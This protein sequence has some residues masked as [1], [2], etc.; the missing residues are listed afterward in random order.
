[1][2][3]RVPLRD[4]AGNILKWYG[5]LTDIEDRKRAEALL[6]GEKRVLELVAKGNPLAEIL[7]SLCTLVEEQASDALASILLV[8]GDRLKHGG[9]PSLP[10]A[11]TDAID[12]VL[13]GPSVGSCGTAAY[14]GQQVVVEDIATDSLWTNFR[15]AA[16]PHGLHACWSTPVFSSHGQ[17]IATFAMYYREPR[18]PTQ[19][20]QEII[21]Q[22]THLAGVAIE[23]KVTYD[24]LQRSEAYLAEAQRL[25]H[26]GSWAIEPINREF[27]YWSDEMFRILDFDPQHGKAS[28]QQMWQLIHPQD[29]DRVKELSDRTV[30]E[31]KDYDYE[32]RVVLPSG[33]VKHLLT[34]GH[35]DLN[36]QG[37][38]IEVVG[39]TIDVT[40][41]K[42]YLSDLQAAE[43]KFRG[44]LESAP[45]AVAVVNRVGTIVLVN[46]QLEKLFGYQRTE[47]LGNK[48]E[49][50]LP[51]RFRSKHPELRTAF[52]AD[53]HTRPM[54]S[55]LELYGLHK[56][57]R[58]FPVEV[59][60]S[61]LETEEGVLISGA[62]RD[63]TDRKQAE[64]KIRHSEAELRQLWM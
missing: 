43:Q 14:R 25:T 7:D 36:S 46:A 26:T 10:K 50:L 13:I 56:D 51:E 41:R 9:A 62:I 24:Q 42:R 33:A 4:E 17:V 20:D 3:R 12:G 1:M 34:S 21:E 29:R 64:E 32:F 63:I 6:S 48:I 57:G 55:R 8:Q 59:S 54:G 44:L 19:R 11:Y 53:P 47:V 60:L 2:I 38:M 28:R 16:L 35:P 23:G 37:E 18:R 15:D 45:D 22:I 5:V 31:Q 27:L 30:R 49:M 58:E 40:E 52:V 61:P 39:T